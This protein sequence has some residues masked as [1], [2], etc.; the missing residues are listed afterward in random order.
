MLTIARDQVSTTIIVTCLKKVKISETSQN[1]AIISVVSTIHPV[2][3][4]INL[5][6]L[7][8]ETL[9]PGASAKSFLDFDKYLQRN[10]ALITEEDILFIYAPLIWMFCR[11]T[12]CSKIDKI[13]HFNSD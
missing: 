9:L 7:Q 3:S 10:N 8:M 11:K 5:K 12:F 6:S 13:H 2:I 4:I 1:E